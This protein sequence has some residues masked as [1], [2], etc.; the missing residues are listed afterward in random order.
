MNKKSL[1]LFALL[2]LLCNV[3]QAYGYKPFVEDGKVWHL[4]YSTY[5]WE[6][7]EYI[8]HYFD[9]KIDGDTTIAGIACKK[10][11][12]LNVD[13]DREI[14]YKMA[15]Y[16]VDRKVYKFERGSQEPKLLYDFSNLT[17]GDELGYVDEC[18]IV[19]TH[20]C[21]RR[22]YHF[23]G[24]FLGGLWVEGVGGMTEPFDYP[25][26]FGRAGLIVN[27]VNCKLN[28]L[29]IFD[30]NDFQALLNRTDVGSQSEDVNT[31]GAVDID[32]VNAVINKILHK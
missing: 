3:M 15:L 32:D 26:D 16:E 18:R 10:L 14:G 4:E 29:T 6:N 30:E 5:D 31:D 28:G 1:T 12:A 23:V 7:D 2:A 17:I 19:K 21:E 13:R 11:Y 8:S 24:E 25:N 27:I 22:A 9:Y 20:G